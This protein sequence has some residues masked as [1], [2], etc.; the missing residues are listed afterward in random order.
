MSAKEILGEE[1]YTI[2]EKMF[3]KVKQSSK[4][5]NEVTIKELREEASKTDNKKIA[6]VFMGIADC[7]EKNEV[8]K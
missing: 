1:V 2:I 5:S 8:T 7:I 3:V 4:E 6:L